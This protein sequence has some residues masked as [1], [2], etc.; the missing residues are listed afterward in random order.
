MI[1]VAVRQSSA[2]PEI[3]M[4]GSILLCEWDYPLDGIKNCSPQQGEG[5][6]S[7][8]YKQHD[9]YKSQFYASDFSAMSKTKQTY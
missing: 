4:K 5:S 1:M 7:T 6:Y 9:T 3:F 2:H 8:I